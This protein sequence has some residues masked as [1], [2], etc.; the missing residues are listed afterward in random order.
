M[1]MEKCEEQC[2]ERPEK[3]IRLKHRRNVLKSFLRKHSS[4]SYSRKGFCSWLDYEDLT[5]L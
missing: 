2:K 5:E 3:A 4:H 1:H